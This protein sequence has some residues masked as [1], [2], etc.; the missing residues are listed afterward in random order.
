MNL[1]VFKSFLFQRLQTNQKEPPQQLLP[2]QQLLSLKQ[3]LL[4]P[5]KQQL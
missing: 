4:P 5:E 3:Q 1:K 2:E